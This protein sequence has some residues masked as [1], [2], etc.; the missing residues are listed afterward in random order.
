M[1]DLLK[2]SSGVLERNYEVE[3]YNTSYFRTMKISDIFKYLQELASKHSEIL[4]IG[5]DDL[6]S[7]N[8][9][10]V[11]TKQLIN[12]T[13][14]P[15]ALE[16][17]KVYTWCSYVT[18]IT[19]FRN[20][21]VVDEKENELVKVKTEWVIINLEKRRIIPMS[22]IRLPEVTK[23]NNDFYNN[24]IDKVLIQ[25][26]DLVNSFEKQVRFTDIDINGH[27]NNIV[28]LDM[29]IDS[30]A[31][32]LDQYTP[33]VEINSNFIKEARFGDKL[34]IE[35]CKLSAKEFTHSIIRKDDNTELFKAKSIFR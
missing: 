17:F 35:T 23:I 4:G 3:T 29:L 31:D 30:I 34:K 13:R 32:Y 26:N 22:K 20:F 5:F 6:K 24:K 1:L 16:K 33:L 27:M 28:Y 18:K 2:N 12:I 8:G 15:N 21:L 11:L 7:Q 10:W 9:A 19:A 14:L 25:E